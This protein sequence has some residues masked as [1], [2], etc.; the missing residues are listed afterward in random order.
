MLSAANKLK[1]RNYGN[2]KYFIEFDIDLDVVKKLF[3]PQ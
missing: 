2:L 1:K 3:G